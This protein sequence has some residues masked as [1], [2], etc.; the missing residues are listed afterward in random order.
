MINILKRTI[1][2]FFISIAF[3]FVYSSNFINCYI[4]KYIIIIIAFAIIDLTYYLKYK[5]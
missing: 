2:I 4:S 1:Q 5:I 3:T